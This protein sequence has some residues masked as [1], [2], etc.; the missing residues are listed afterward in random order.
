MVSE[1]GLP[2]AEA[3]QEY[4]DPHAWNIV[5]GQLEEKGLG[6]P[7]K[8]KPDRGV[9]WFL[10]KLG[11][12][13]LKKLVAGKLHA[14]AH[15][16]P[17]KLDSERQI[18]PPGKWEIL[19]PNYFASSASGVGLELID[20]R[21]FQSE[22][23]ALADAN[24]LPHGKGRKPKKYTQNV[25]I[26]KAFDEMCK[27]GKVSFAHGGQ[28]EAARRLQKKFPYYVIGTIRKMIQGTYNELKDKKDG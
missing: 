13:L 19:H 18:I 7:L 21:V 16:V 10:S 24:Q 12:G 9:R 5:V 26:L 27:A 22:P 23:A 3:L 8:S 4:S 1:E 28:I 6:W 14:T 15:L 11:Q 2:L 20:I 17:R 25:K